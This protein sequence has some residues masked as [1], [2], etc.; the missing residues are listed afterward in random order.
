MHRGES[1]ISGKGVH[2]YKAREGVPFADVISF[3]LNISMRPN[4][5]IFIGY[6]KK[7]EVGGPPLMHQVH[8]AGRLLKLHQDVTLWTFDLQKFQS[9]Q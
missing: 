7:G 2:M 5:F 4:Y 1:R 3:F 6:L 9:V 8:L